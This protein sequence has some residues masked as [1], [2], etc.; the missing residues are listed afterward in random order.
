MEPDPGCPRCGHI[1]TLKNRFIE[2]DYVRRIWDIAI[3]HSRAA[4]TS[5]PANEPLS[6]AALGAYKNSNIAVLTLNSELLHRING[7]KPENYLI[8]PKAFVK[9]A[10]K[11]VLRNEK[12]MVKAKMG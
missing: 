4:I 8:H 11:A 9:N 7:L 6:N 3:R 5:D 12:K 10:L 1:E 2:C